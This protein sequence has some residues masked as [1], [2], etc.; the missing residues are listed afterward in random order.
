MN[1]K[2]KNSK[3]AYHDININNQIVISNIIYTNVIQKFFISRKSKK[4]SKK[5]PIYNKNELSILIGYDKDNNSNIIV[6]ESGLYQN[7][8][9]TGT[10][11]SGKTSSSMYPFTKQ[12]L[13]YNHNKHWNLKYIRVKITKKATK[14]PI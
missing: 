14:N 8:L 4:S 12:L 2:M 1:D 7:F 6:P 13:L 11:G 9:I 10:I 3:K 5:I